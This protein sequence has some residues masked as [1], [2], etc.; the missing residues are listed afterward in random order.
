MAQY[1]SADV[2]FVLIDGYSVLGTVTTLQDSVEAIV[3]ESTTFGVEWSSFVN[4]DLRKGALSQSGFFDDAVGSIHEALSGTALASV[5]DSRVF[6]YGLEGNTVGQHFIGYGG[7]I[8]AKYERGLALEKLHMAS[9][10]YNPSG[11]VEVGQILKIN[12]EI[13][14]DYTPAG[15]GVDQAADTRVTRIPITSNSLAN[16]SV[17]TTT[18]NHGFTN[19]DVVLIAGVITSNPTIN[20]E[21]VATVTGLNTFTVPV[22]VGTAGT[23]G[24]AVRAW[25]KNGGAGYLSC[26][27][28]SL[29]GW[30]NLGVKVQHSSDNASFVDLLSFTAIT[31]APFAERKEVVA[32]TTVNRYLAA[33]W[34]FA[35]GGAAHTA[36]FTVG[37][38]RA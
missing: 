21:R 10:V 16:P 14:A 25:T 26:S 1:S 32:G 15:S 29:G 22:N 9:A 37:F 28:I 19:S 6:M 34:A 18:V 11:P 4:V 20:G 3:Q 31:A 23:G 38:V 36:T 2:G 7:A 17:V 24:T 13:S 33:L 5:G 30:T 8:E 35:G 12:A 27:A